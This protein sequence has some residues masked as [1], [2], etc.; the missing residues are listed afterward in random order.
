VHP[1]AVLAAQRGDLRQRVDAAGIHGAAGRDHCQRNAPRGAVA[2]DRLTQVRE[3]HAE[4]LI[5][6]DQSQLLASE[7]EQRHRLGDRHVYFTRGIHDAGPGTGGIGRQACLASHGK[8]HQVRHRAAAA[9]AAAT[10]V[11]AERRGEHVD[12]PTLERH[13]R[14]RGAPRGDVLVEDARQQV[15]KGGHRLARPVHVAEEAR[16]GRAAEVEHLRQGVE[17]G[18]TQSLF[19]QCG[20]ERL[21]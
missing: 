8:C 20:T 1:Q 7:P 17:R 3:A 18:G 21:L 6:R 10:A 15:R 12:H 4:A 11:T 14:R 16:G 13:R 19:G 2:R 5:G 9:E